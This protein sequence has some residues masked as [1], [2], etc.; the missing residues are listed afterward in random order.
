MTKRVVGINPDFADH[1]EIDTEALDAVT[2]FE[3]GTISFEELKVMVGYESAKAIQ[4][5]IHGDG[6]RADNLFDDPED[7]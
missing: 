3:Q 5:K 4:S 1:D 2:E 6:S 7:F